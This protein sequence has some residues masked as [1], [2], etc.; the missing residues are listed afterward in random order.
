MIKVLGIN[1]S[2]RKGANSQF[3]L[4]HAMRGAQDAAKD[5]SAEMYNITGKKF[6]GC[7]NC[8]KCAEL[9]GECV[10]KD[11]F[12][13]LR[14]KWVGSDVILYSLPVFHMSMP[15]QIRCFIDRLGNTQFCYYDMAVPRVMKVIGGITQGVHLFSGQ[16]QVLT[17]I[18][19]HAMVMG[20][21]YTNGDLWESYAGAGGWTNNEMDKDA[22]KKAYERNELDAV[23]AVKAAYSVGRRSTELA[24]LLHSGARA[25]PDI[26][27]SQETYKA[28]AARINE[29]TPN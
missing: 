19:N 23:T 3:L 24:L 10:L 17:A 2:T 8:G 11:D 15:G 9:K 1:G 7:L 28:F 21:L 22:L 14:D 27:G 20:S 13:E 5:V 16:E 29:T 18:S 4:E 6:A 12:Q 26:V 25:R